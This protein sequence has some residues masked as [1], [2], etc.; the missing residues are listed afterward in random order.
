MSETTDT[1]TERLIK[2]SDQEL[3]REIDKMLLPFEDLLRDGTGWL[4]KLTPTK[5]GP[6]IEVRWG[7]AL[8]ELKREAF[9]RR[10]LNRQTMKLDQFMAK[11]ERLQSELSELRDGL[12]T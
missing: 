2:Q 11:F 3:K 4:L 10:R 9:Q 8:E 5:G 7:T 12:D 1:I 6:E